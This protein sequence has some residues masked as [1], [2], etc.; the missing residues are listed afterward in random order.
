MTEVSIC[1]W[2]RIPNPMIPHIYTFVSYATEFDVNVMRFE[3]LYAGSYTLFAIITGRQFTFLEE[4]GFDTWTFWCFTWSMNPEHYLLYLNAAA[5]FTVDVP[6]NPSNIMIEGG[7]VLIL[8]QEQG[9][10]GN[11]FNELKS[12]QGSITEFHLWNRFIREQEI[13]ILMEAYVNKS[14]YGGYCQVNQGKEGG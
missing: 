8:G 13:R 3:N 11:S 1:T 6:G 10:L 7:G 5:V 9:E 4:P 2:V 14:P 12:F